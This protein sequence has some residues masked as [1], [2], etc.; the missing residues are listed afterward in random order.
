MRRREDATRP[1]RIAALDG[2]RGVAVVGVVLFHAGGLD[3]GF[4]GVDLFFVLS[5]YLITGLLLDDHRLGR[6]YARRLRRLAPALLVLVLA[7]GLLA[8]VLLDDAVLGDVRARGAATLLYVA[9]WHAIASEGDYFA[10]LAGSNPLEHTWSLAIEEQVYLV[11]PLL[12]LLALRV[13]RRRPAHDVVLGLAAALAVLSLAAWAL[14]YEPGGGTARAYYGTDTRAFAVLAGAVVAAGSRRPGMQAWTRGPVAA[15]TAAV[16]GAALAVTWVVAEGTDEALYR[17]L[18]PAAGIAGAVVVGVVAAR[19]PRP[20]A[21][22][23]LVGLGVISYGLYLWHWPVFVVLDRDRTGLDGAA[24]AALRIAAS[25]AI[26]VLSYVVVE[27]PVRFGSWCTPARWRLALP[28]A[29]VVAAAGLLLGT[30]G[31]DDRPRG[32]AGTSS[33][34]GVDA[35]PDGRPRLLLLGDSQAFE[36]AYRGAGPGFERY[37]VA[38]ST[39]LG[40]GIGPGLPASDAGPVGRSLAGEACDAVVPTWRQALA[41]FEPDVVLVHVGAWE[42]LDRWIDDRLVAFGSAEWDRA[43]AARIGEV[44]DALGD[45]GRGGRRWRVAWVA[46]PCFAGEGGYGGHPARAEAARVARW[47]ELLRAAAAGRGMAVLPYDR[48]TCDGPAADDDL[49][50]VDF[51]RGGI[52][53]TADAAPLVWTWIADHLHG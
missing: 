20:L 18:L 25:V 32:A 12:V 45:G 27:R 13:G 39:F 52:H 24:L 6:F 44:M 28:G 36:L 15:A 46:A 23:P 5:G 49:G 34:A 7:V 4:L 38:S 53:V 26:A 35:S 11:W 47:N 30:A 1:A 17:G 31:G 9:N 2:L 3:G 29:A 14:A 37:Q 16:A 42:V 19:D 33:T 21:A 40:C 51:R 8:P 22:P 48:F 41:R 50:G 10:A 43:S